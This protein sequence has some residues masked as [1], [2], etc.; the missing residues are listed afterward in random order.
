MNAWRTGYD[1]AGILEHDHPPAS[2]RALA[3]SA[4]LIVSS[5]LP[6]AIA[7][8]ERLVGDRQILLSAL[9]REAPGEWPAWPSVRLPRRMWEIAVTLRWGYRILRGTDVPPRDRERGDAAARWLIDLTRDHDH[10]VVVTHGIFRRILALELERMGWRPDG[11]RRS[12]AN[13]SV[14]SLLRRAG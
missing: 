13:W 6:R 10:V 8:A 3:D 7:T 2:L 11:A 5:D 14:W 9:L 4:D 12:Y 1:E